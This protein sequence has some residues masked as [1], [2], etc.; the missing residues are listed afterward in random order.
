MEKDRINVIVDGAKAN[1]MPNSIYRGFGMISANNSSRLLLD[2]KAEHPEAYWNILNCIFGKEGLGATHFKL[3]MG[4]DINSSSGTEPCIMRRADEEPDVTRG[5][6]YQLAFDAKQINPDI[7]LDMLRWSE[8]AWISNAD[9]VYDL[10]YQWYKSTLDAAFKE[11]GLIFD[12]ISA[13]QNERDIDAEWIKY[14]S[15]R[16]KNEKDSAYDYS[17]I[18]I[19]AADEEGHWN[20][21]EKMLTDQVLLDAVDVIGSH[22]TDWSTNKVKQLFHDYGKKVWFSEGCPPMSYSEETYRYDGTGSGLTGINGVLDIANRIITMYPGGNMTLYE[23]QPAVA[24]YYDGVTFCSKQLITANKPWSGYYEL[25]SG[26][27]MALHFSQFIKEGWCFIE[28][29]CA[30]DGKPGGDGHAVVEATYSYITLCDPKTEDY[31]IVVTNT[32]N[33]TREY[34]IEISELKKSSSTVYIWET[35][36]PEKNQKFDDNYFKKID[37]INPVSNGN[38]DTYTVSVKPY[39]MV[40]ITTLN[41]ENHISNS[42]NEIDNNSRNEID[43][44]SSNLLSIPYYDDY[45]YK[46]YDKDYLLSRGNAP[47]YTTDEGGAFEVVHYNGNNV[48]MQKITT[49]MK[50]KE[51]GYTPDPVTNFGDDLWFNYKASVDVKFDAN[52][53]QDNNYVGVGIR[54]NLGDAGASGY[55]MILYANG[56]WK[57]NR[58]KVMITEGYTERFD[59]SIWNY[60]GVMAVE[61]K[62][63]AYCNGKLLVSHTVDHKNLEPMHTAGRCALYSSYHCNCFDHF[64]AEPIDDVEYFV[65]RINNTNEAI[66]Y[67]SGWTH[68]VM[69]GFKNYYR[70]VSKGEIGESVAIDFSGTGFAI[71]GENENE[72]NCE[73]DVELDGILVEHK[74]SIAKSDYREACYYR[75]SIAE[76]YHQMKITVLSGTFTLDAVEIT[77]IHKAKDDK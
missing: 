73:I 77:K 21:G 16:L 1:K 38:I 27:Y 10:R 35:R 43:N 25:N 30:G 56:R 8:P 46:E 24:A 52:G 37:A 40:T 19:V 6:S 23:F 49:D 11:Y 53:N 60:I 22:Y 42:K 18:K 17:K 71:I 3:E 41:E 31:S 29:A 12:Y 5:A 64:K 59:G 28:G 14:I 51:W 63:S 15:K 67:S 39:S 36:G 33:N 47:R 9:D 26:Y 69:S 72:R 62:I 54:Y 65:D 48:L 75:Y 34:S 4:S 7:T 2:Y 58:N 57:L 32:T 50:P 66:T 76:G 45:E 20:I 74:L 44:N 13:N 55:S 61:D 70:T 68:S